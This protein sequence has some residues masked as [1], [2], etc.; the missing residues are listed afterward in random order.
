LT[1]CKS[2]ASKHCNLATKHELSSKVEAGRPKPWAHYVEQ[3]PV[4]GAVLQVDV[5]Q[6]KAAVGAAY[7]RDQH[8]VLPL[9]PAHAA[10]RGHACRADSVRDLGPA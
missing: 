8:H 4:L 10:Q 2:K 9:L 5:P 6:L 3:L 1:R 7:V